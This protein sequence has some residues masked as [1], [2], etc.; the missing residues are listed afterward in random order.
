MK[1]HWIE[2]GPAWVDSPLSYWV[3]VEADDR[4]YYESERFDP[5]RPGPVPGRGYARL[6]VEL[7]GVTLE[8]SSLAELDHLI[9][10]LSRK[11]LPTTRS[12]SARRPGGR[13][14]NSH[15]LSRLPAKAKPWRYRQ[16]AVRYLSEVRGALPGNF[17]RQ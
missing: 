12:L 13:G 3:H 4:P 17:G 2:Y 16:R 10:V 11:A 6:F 7:D 9:E 5:P 14:P 1:R 8:F 15:W